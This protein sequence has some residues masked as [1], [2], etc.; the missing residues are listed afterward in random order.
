MSS[1]EP[2]P[3]RCEASHLDAVPPFP[4][5]DQEKCETNGNISKVPT[6]METATIFIWECGL[7]YT[8][9]TAYRG[10]LVIEMAR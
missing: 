4:T 6:L 8:P 9:K 3:Y 1:P 2:L 5:L 10:D 7:T